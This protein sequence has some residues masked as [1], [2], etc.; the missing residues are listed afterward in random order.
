MKYLKGITT[1]EE[2]KRAY[3][4]W[5]LKLHPDRGGSTEEM[6]I[7]NA[8]YEQLFSKVSHVHVNKEGK[9]YERP[10]D[11]RP[12]E[13]VELIDRLLRMDGVH[14]EV[15]VYFV[16]LSGNTKAHKDEIKTLG[17]K[18]HSVKK[19]WYLAPPWY[20]KYNNRQYSMDEIR[21]MFG[22]RYEGIGKGNERI[23]ER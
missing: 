9:K 13:F 20:T 16:W 6:Q 18:W 4:T 8:E 19:M 2:L 1:L 5:A 15:I 23:G 3:R 10:V 21:D 17:F 14:I 12:D 7:L 22:V 11:E